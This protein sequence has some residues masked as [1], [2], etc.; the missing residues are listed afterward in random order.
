[1]NKLSAS[2]VHLKKSSAETTLV[3][4]HLENQTEIVCAAS[5]GKNLQVRSQWRKK[6]ASAQSIV[7]KISCP[8]RNHDT[9]PGKK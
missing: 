6:F 1:M 3:M 2:E 4:R 5:G 9:S 8:P 7:E